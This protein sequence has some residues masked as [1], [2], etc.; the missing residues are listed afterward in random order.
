MEKKAQEKQLEV[1]ALSRRGP[2]AGARAPLGG[3]GPFNKSLPKISSP[4]NA[5]DEILLI[6]GLLF[7]LLVLFLFEKNAIKMT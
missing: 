3:P 4:A 2:R 5:G 7:F 6:G 1:R